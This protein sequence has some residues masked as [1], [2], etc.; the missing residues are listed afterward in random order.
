MYRIS[1]LAAQLSLSRSTLLYYERKGLITGKRQSNGYR[2]YGEKDLQRLRLFQQLQAG[3]LSLQECKDCLDGKL[4]R[5]MLHRRMVQL[6]AEIEAKQRASRL[7]SALLGKGSLRSWH[8]VTDRVAPDAY[9]D[10]IKQQ[11]FSERQ[12]LH[13]KWLSKDMNQ[14]DQYM[15]DFMAVFQGLDRWGPGSE[16]D[17][18]KALALVPIVPTQV[19]D[20]GCGK[21]LATIILAEKT[22]AQVVAVDNEAS[23]LEALKQRLVEQ[24]LQDRVRTECASMTDL[25]FQTGSFDL[26]WAEAS[27]YV[28]G[29]EKALTTWKKFLKPKGCIVVNDLVW[30]TDTPSQTAVDFW[31]QEYPDMQS[32]SL[33]EQQIRRA[34]YTVIDHFSLSQQAWAN[35]YEPL[36]SRLNELKPQMAESMALNDIDR[37]IGI[38]DQYLG[39]FGYE[40]FILQVD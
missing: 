33:R 17:T 15:A 14:H 34:G 26:I 29:F 27:A 25:P 11:G 38:I 2:F 35:Y 21:G 30:L 5:D 6:N 23:A 13:L 39:E 36:R 24:G 20:I 40:M 28:M 22:Q 19:V 3:G 37:E 16:E 10:W 7:L 31:H 18:V 32:V 4:D 9:L 8:Q 12:A 1:E